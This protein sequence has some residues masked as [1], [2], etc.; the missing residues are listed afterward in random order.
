MIYDLIDG[1]TKVV[2]VMIT[3][4]SQF[5]FIAVTS[6]VFN[7]ATT[8][9]IKQYY[10][11]KICKYATTIVALYDT[12]RVAIELLKENEVAHGNKSTVRSIA[13]EQGGYSA[14]I[15]RSEALKYAKKGD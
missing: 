3:N 11:N 8:L 13:Y 10:K 1:L 6:L 9:W 2:D 5:T 14:K 4:P 7:I 12:E 15:Y